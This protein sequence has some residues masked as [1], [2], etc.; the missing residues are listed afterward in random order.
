METL[1]IHKDLLKTDLLDKIVNMFLNENVRINL[2]PELH[3]HMNAKFPLA[4]KFNHEY[5]DLELTIET[6]GGVEDA[7]KHINSH[8]SNHT[9]CIITKNSKKFVFL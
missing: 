6:T 2:G 1:L 5:S 8:G 7:I 3:K 9:E 4:K